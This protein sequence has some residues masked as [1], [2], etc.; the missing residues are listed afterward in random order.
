M[1]L[2]GID[3]GGKRTGLALSDERGFLASGVG[4]IVAE[5]M[6]SLVA[7]LAQKV[8]ELGVTGI[9]LG[10]PI[11]M[12]GTR[13]ESSERAEKLAEKLR[14]ATGLPV[15]LWDERRTTMAA[16]V[17]LNATDTR[18]SRRKAA[19]DTLSAEIILQ[20]YLDMLRMRGNI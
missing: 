16:A 14:E 18:G 1:R 7:Q 10:N 12:N 6:N 9:V 11:N 20:D 8:Q 5:G 13:G 2:L 17:Y 3:Y 4:R 15:T 19:V